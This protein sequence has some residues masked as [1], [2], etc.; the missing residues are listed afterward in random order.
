MAFTTSLTDERRKVILGL[1]LIAGLA[2][3]LIRRAGI[4]DDAYITFRTVDNFINGYGLT[5]NP[6]ER[7]QTYTHP[8][9]MLLLSG[10]YALTRELFWTSTILSLLL[11]TAAVAL[12]VLGLAKD[13]PRMVLGMGLLALSKAFVD[14][15]TSGLENPLIYVLL[16]LFLYVYFRPWRDSTPLQLSLLAALGLT[17]R[18]DTAL[19]FL[20]ALAYFFWRQPSRR[21]LKQIVIGMLPLLLWEAFSVFYYGFPF[22]NTAY[23]KLNTGIPRLE[24]LEQG[25]GYVSNLL[26]FDPLSLLVILAGLLLGLFSNRA[27]QYPIVLGIGL[28]AAYTVWIGGDFMGGRYFAAPVLLAVILLVRSPLL[29]KKTIWAGLLAAAL[30]G[31]QT[32]HNPLWFR[33][34]TL[35]QADPV[36]YVDRRGISDERLNYQLATGLLMA[37]R[38]RDLPDHVWAWQGTRD[39]HRERGVVVKFAVGFYGFFVG[40]ETYVL[41]QLAL[42]DPLLARLPAARDVHW[43]I[44]HF[45]RALPDGY[46]RTLRE[47]SNQ[48]KDPNLARYYDSLS[49]ITRG[50]LLSRSRLVEIWRMNSGYY[51]AL[52]DS[53]A[54]RFPEQIMLR[55]S[56]AGFR[57]APIELT[58]SGVVIKLAQVSHAQTL[59]I[60]LSSADAYRMIYKRDGQMVA[61]QRLRA[62]IF[63]E[64]GLAQ[65]RLVVP[66]EA[67]DAGFDEIWVLPVQGLGPYYFGGLK[68]QD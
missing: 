24:L 16:V 63:P 43:R 31:L 45:V 49:L 50:P 14:Y 67:Q 41:D 58:G 65:H 21:A 6:G 38:D 17:T 10:A 27:R 68:L 8:L 22:P 4:S 48:I 40:P 61:E 55:L 13:L 18:L 52:I 15:S 26:E 19:L 5:W 7:V 46:E 53:N 30:I 2:L 37:N 20:P 36:E 44:G 42:G 25:L 1:V 34:R 60:W 56:A 54:F 29:T 62:P 33:D 66:D 12:I 9:W 28:Y 39:R 59:T 51:E 3:V 23:A 47:G 35:R 11:A 64:Q 32:P 57:R